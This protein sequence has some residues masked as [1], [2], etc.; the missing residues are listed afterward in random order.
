MQAGITQTGS[1]VTE[2]ENAPSY[3]K[4]HLLQSYRRMGMPQ[5]EDS[6]NA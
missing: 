3:D 2:S 6:G 1:N 4:K 5:N